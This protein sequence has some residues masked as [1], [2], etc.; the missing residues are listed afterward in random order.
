MPERANLGKIFVVGGMLLLVVL[1]RAAQAEPG[2]QVQFA[3]QSVAVV[4][5]SPLDPNEILAVVQGQPQ[6]SY[7][8]GATW[9][10]RRVGVAVRSVAFDPVVRGRILAG[11]DDGL[12]LSEDD[13]SGWHKLGDSI[14]AHKLVPAVS[15][16]GGTVYAAMYDGVGTRLAVYRFDAGGNAMNTNIPYEGTSSFGF[17]PERNRLYVGTNPGVAYS[18]DSGQ[19]WQ[20]GGVGGQFVSRI[21]V[22]PD[23]VW[24]LSADGLYRSRD[25][26]ASWDKLAD[27]DAINGTRY[28]NDMHLSGLSV[29]NGAAF[30]G[31]WSFSYPYKFLVSF[32]GGSARSTLDAKVND[33]AA[34]SS[35]WAASESGLWSNKDALTSEARIRR[36]VIIIPGILGSM[37]TSGSLAQYFQHLATGT[38]RDAPSPLVLDPIMHV[39]D[40]LIAGLKAHGYI[41]DKTLFTFPYDWMQDNGLTARQLAD[42]IAVVKSQCGC[43]QVDIVAHSMGGLVA[44]AYIQSDYYHG[45]VR[46]LIQIATPNAGS[47]DAYP[48]WESG[49]AGLKP[50][51]SNQLLNLIISAATDSHLAPTRTEFVREYVPSV[52]QLLP[53]FNYL[54]AR[55]YPQGYPRN[56]FVEDLNQLPGIESLRQR[57]TL[58]TVGSDSLPTLNGLNVTESAASL[59]WPDGKIIASHNGM[60][61]GTVLLSSLTAIAPLSQLLTADHHA[62]VTA[63]E[64]FV[65]RILMGGSV[66]EPVFKPSPFPR[67]LAIALPA[68]IKLRLTDSLGRIVDPAKITIPGAYYSG[69]QASPQILTVPLNAVGALQLELSVDKPQ[70]ITLDTT[71]LDN[72]SESLSSSLALTLGPEPVI[73]YLDPISNTWI[74][75]NLSTTN[76][77]AATPTTTESVTI[78]Q[79]D[80]QLSSAPNPDSEAPFKADLEPD[81]SHKALTA[82]IDP[83]HL[84]HRLWII[85]LVTILIAAW[86]WRPQL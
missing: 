42:R 38:W 56:R 44:R 47:V 80:A 24:A 15:A 67:I 9:Q 86:R 60:G 39:Y 26:A 76:T 4:L 29:N 41:E 58:Y 10:P 79:I 66:T 65:S 40:G 30:Y 81:S 32:S 34:G 53:V 2:W 20:M 78:N 75:P 8:G 3:G 71:T 28:G 25:H 74:T 12:Y 64:P 1:S 72:D 7:D 21:A 43:E 61:D 68:G 62:I 11:T 36:P 37:P 63:A 52:P 70:T 82:I 55:I 31:S 22:R 18:D 16:Y 51:F 77:P 69:A 5:V 83:Q 48:T 23:A 49:D 17:D 33:V 35:L 45:D 84:R 50:D 54:N 46:N 6:I 19:H 13:G 85:T 14:L 57:V 27:P 59:L 73:L